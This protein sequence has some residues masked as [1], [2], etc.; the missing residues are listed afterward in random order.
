MD[1][2]KRMGIDD[3]PV[4]IPAN[5]KGSDGPPQASYVRIMSGSGIQV[6]SDLVP[7]LD[8][9]VMES[10]DVMGDTTGL[11]PLV[12]F[13][14]KVHER[15]DHNM[16]RS[17]IVHLLGR[18]IGYKTLVGRIRVLWQAQGAF[19]PRE[20]VGRS[21]SMASTN[22]G[23][24]GSRFSVLSEVEDAGIGSG[25]AKDGVTGSALLQSDPAILGMCGSLTEVPVAPVVANGV[26]T[27][28]DG[29][30]LR[31]VNTNIQ[32]T[33]QVVSSGGGG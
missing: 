29:V 1:V 17:L 15:I 16:H 3:H 7:S 32:D 23:I 10:D 4:L 5:E 33:V 19:Q 21:K 8:D 28:S 13:S 22:A 18:S 9:V 12:S 26:R 30:V 25:N 11:F 20:D 2:L 24:G 27:A 31:E 14:E 6:V